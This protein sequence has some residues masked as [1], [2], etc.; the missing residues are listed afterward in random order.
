MPPKNAGKGGGNQSKK[1]DQKKK[2]KV[3]EVLIQNRFLC[4]F[5]KQGQCAKG[6]KCKFSH[7]LNIERR[8]EKRSAY[9]DTRDDEKDTSENWDEETL[10]DV[11]EKK[12][13]K[14][15]ASKPS[16]QIICRFF[17]DAVEEGKYGWFWECPNGEKCIYRHALPSGYILKKDRKKMDREKEDISLEDLIER[18]R[19]ALGSTTT[20]V[21]LETFLAWK[22]KKLKEREEKEKKDTDKKKSDY[23]SGKEGGIS[24]REMFMFNPDLAVGENMEEGDADFDFKNMKEE[25]E[26]GEEEEVEVRYME[27]DLNALRD[28]Y[29]TM[30]VARMML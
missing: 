8:S 18:E 13:G 6:A 27:I 12:H 26:E 24:G 9:C 17:L 1:A 28:E 22:K 5:F 14:E 25:P 15:S 21:T 29:I 20:K 10:K 7:D 11:V 3:I 16:T 30:D 2:E 4:S 23:K 19:A